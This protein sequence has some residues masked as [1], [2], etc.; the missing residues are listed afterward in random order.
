[1]D[2]EFCCDKIVF[3]NHSDEN[4]LLVGF[5]NNG[6]N[7]TEYIILQKALSFDEQDKELGMDT[8]YLEYYF[9]EDTLVGYG[10]CKKILALDK[11][12][13]FQFKSNKFNIECLKIDIE[14]QFE[15]YNSTSFRKIFDDIYK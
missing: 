14:K 7:P 9:E 3:E 6:D 10:I 1:M 2:K 11:K 5:S 4:Y 13:V 12:I 8:Y 15:I